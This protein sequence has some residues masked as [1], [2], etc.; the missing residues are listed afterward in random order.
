M[1]IQAFDVSAH[2]DD[3]ETIRA[4]LSAALEDP[5]P[6]AFL[7]ALGNVAKARGIAQLAEA[8]GVGRQSLYKTLASGAQ[9]RYATVLK[10]ISALGLRL[11]VRGVNVA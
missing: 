4:Y 9:P 1:A 8:A 3:E 11:D 7:L 5:N 2:L 10:L 6:D